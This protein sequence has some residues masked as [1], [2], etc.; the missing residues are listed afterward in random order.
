MNNSSV[1]RWWLA[2]ALMLVI[3]PTLLVS[4]QD[5]ETVLRPTLTDDPHQQMN[6]LIGKV[7]LR[8]REI[9]DLLNDAAAGKRDALGAVGSSGIDEILKASR[10]RA[11]QSVED[12]DKI[13]ELADHP[14]EPG[15]T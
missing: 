9:N 5:K 1:P 13:L 7:E 4:A 3:A 15:G 14:H 6:E 12:I 10:E 2:G 11:R 8:L